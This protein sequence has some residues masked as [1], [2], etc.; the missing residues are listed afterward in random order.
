[1]N[2]EYVYQIL[3]SAVS[4][5]ALIGIVIF[6]FRAWFIERL[7]GS[8]KFEYDQKI[9]AYK[10]ELEKHTL[11]HNVVF[12]QL[13]MQ[14]ITVISECYAYL[15]DVH[16]ALK[17]YTKIFSPVGDTKIECRRKDFTNTMNKF[18]KFYRKRRLF[19]PKE[20]TI[21]IDKIN[22]D[23]KESYYDFHYAVDANHYTPQ[24]RTMKWLEIDNKV[25][26]GISKTLAELE[27]AFR[28]SLGEKYKDITL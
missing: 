14:R 28:E 22:K 7:K 15:N 13:H 3:I 2:M 1:M 10:K 25:G 4:S 6:I 19:I 26:V 17:E 23:F 12:T 18:M 5:S 9:E 11:E 27:N 21:L 20:H 8:I 16:N 24:E